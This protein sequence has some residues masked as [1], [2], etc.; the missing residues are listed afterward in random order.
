[1]GH[2]GDPAEADV[3]VAVGVDDR[4]A[5]KENIG[6]GVAKRTKTVVLFLT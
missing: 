2:F 4:E 3:L 1:M 5:Q 6:T